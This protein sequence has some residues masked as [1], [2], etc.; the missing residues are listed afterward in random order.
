M[1][2]VRKKPR[3]PSLAELQRLE[4]HHR[5]IAELTASRIAEVKELRQN[6]QPPPGAVVKFVKW[7]SEKMPTG[8]LY[9]AIC[10]GEDK[11]VPTI[12]NNRRDMAKG[13]MT[14]TELLKLISYDQAWVV[15]DESAWELL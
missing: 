8:Y 1:S 7:P 9:A 3:L 4:Q 6:R 15:K 5:Q 10:I 12:Q 13:Y 2:V 14:W 11:W